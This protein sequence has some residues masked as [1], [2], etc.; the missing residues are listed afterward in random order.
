MGKGRIS[1]PNGL[2]VHSITQETMR[3]KE[4]QKKE[5][6]KKKKEFPMK[7]KYFL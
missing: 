1:P 7:K 6:P 5:F 2:K 3:S 4:K